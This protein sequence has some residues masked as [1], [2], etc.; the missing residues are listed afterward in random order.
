MTPLYKLTQDQSVKTT[1]EELINS[2]TAHPGLIFDKFPNGWDYTQK[3]IKLPDGEGGAKEKW[4]IDAATRNQDHL[5]SNLEQAIKRQKNLTKNLL[6][7]T[8]ELQTDWRFITGLGN[9]H[10]YE[11]GFTWHR[12]LGVPYLT[13]SSI[14]GILRDWITNW[15][16]QQE[17]KAKEEANRLLGSDDTDNPHVGSI[18]IFDALPTIPPKL[19][20][21]I[22]N[23]HYQQYYTDPTNPPADYYN[24]VPIKFLTIA[25][26]QS[27]LFTLAARTQT[28]ET[29]NDI[30]QCAKY[31]CEALNTIG[32]GGKTAVGYGVFSESLEASH[33]A[34]QKKKKKKKK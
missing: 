20:V 28:T 4:Y 11:T 19:E 29:T 31:L 26:G 21:D 13:G 7:T 22:L 5:K 33:Y 27:F 34:R 15:T 3:S 24:P 12:T 18:I 1:W 25:A 2:K 14:K 10:P 32:A 8:L 17:N 30:S 16:D 6:G 23:P 9:S